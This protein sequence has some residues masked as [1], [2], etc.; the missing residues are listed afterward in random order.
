[1]YMILSVTVV[2]R[3]W[4]TARVVVHT[5]VPSSVS[6]AGWPLYLCR[7]CMYHLSHFVASH[8]TACGVELPLKRPLRLM[9]GNTGS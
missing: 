9:R 8:S 2:S 1:M 7:I 5:A 3:V 4:Y 6:V